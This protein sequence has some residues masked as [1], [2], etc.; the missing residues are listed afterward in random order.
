MANKVVPCV[1]FKNVTGWI[2]DLNEDESPPQMQRTPDGRDENGSHIK[3]SEI[4]ILNQ[5]VPASLQRL[6]ELL[7]DAEDKK[8]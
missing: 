1:F 4:E 7:R 5:P 8:T 2:I 6:I 3:Q